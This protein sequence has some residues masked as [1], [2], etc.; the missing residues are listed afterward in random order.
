MK[1]SP[2]AIAHRAR[3][4]VLAVRWDVAAPPLRGF[5]SDVI[6][7]WPPDALSRPMKIGQEAI[8]GRRPPHRR[9]ILCQFE[10]TWGDVFHQVH[11]WRES[12]DFRPR[13]WRSRL[14]AY[15]S[16][17]VAFRAP[18]RGIRAHRQPTPGVVTRLWRGYHA[19]ASPASE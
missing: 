15:R 9:S 4:D 10:R 17:E 2:R 5:R 7:R 12:H 19:L 13:V 16:A 6:S 14:S 3:G 18:T 8:A 11:Y 1:V